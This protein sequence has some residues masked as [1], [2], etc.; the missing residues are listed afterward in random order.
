[1]QILCETN[2]PYIVD[3]L[4]APIGVSHFWSFSGHMMD[5]KLEALEYLEETVGPTLKIRAQNLDIEVPA[6]W[7]V[8]AVDRETYT[9]D[10]IPITACATFE[11]DVLLFC[12]TDSKLV[13]TKIKVLDLNQRGS[14]IHPAIPKGSAMVHPTG[15]ERFHNKEGFYGIVCG[16]HDIYRYIGGMTIGDILG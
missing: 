13:T 5:F 16:P 2:K 10:A 4:S 8:I 7:H 14:V 1:M 3:S 9:V 15:P 12:P 11:H 6:S